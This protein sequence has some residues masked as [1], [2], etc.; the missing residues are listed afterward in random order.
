[1]TSFLFSFLFFVFSF[2][3]TSHLFYFSSFYSVFIILILYHFFNFFYIL[4]SDL[5]FSNTVFNPSLFLTFLLFLDHSSRHASQIRRRGRPERGS[6]SLNVHEELDQGED[7][8][9]V[10][11]A[12]FN[13]V[14]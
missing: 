10:M 7:N 13:E 8:Q 1:M 6:L 3:F 12:H 5:Y 11:E 9:R 14:R 4:F 2:F